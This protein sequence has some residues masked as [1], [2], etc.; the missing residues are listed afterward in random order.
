M[1]MI[2][3]TSICP[4][5]QKEW[6]RETYE[7]VPIGFLGLEICNECGGNEE[8]FITLTSLY[9]PPEYVL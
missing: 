2:W 9:R 4:T 6:T 7:G 1:E 8:I 5:C 3:V